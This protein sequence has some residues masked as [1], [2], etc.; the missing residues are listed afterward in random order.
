MRLLVLI[1]L[2][3][4]S[5]PS[6]S[7]SI[8]TS[9]PFLFESSEDSPFSIS[10]EDIAS[11]TNTFNLISSQDYPAADQ[12][13]LPQES[14]NLDFSFL[15]ASCTDPAHEANL[16]LIS[17]LRSR[18]GNT[19]GICGPEGTAETPQSEPERPNDNNDINSPVFNSGP[20]F[21]L[22]V[23]PDVIQ[24]GYSPSICDK[25][26]VTASVAVCDSGVP[27]DRSI[28]LNYWNPFVTVY[29]LENC[30]ICT[31]LHLLFIPAVLRL[32][33]HSPLALAPFHPI[34]ALYSSLLT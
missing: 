30:Y 3:T 34:P 9:D 12:W 24:N 16:P 15:D 27:A 29:T 20:E 17:K 1:L 31:F 25:F 2:S 32:I 6:P 4:A 26:T 21:P 18:A 11:S 19:G 23:F 14:A 13:N 5:F 28:S 7:I 10:S 8:G 33:L 22:L